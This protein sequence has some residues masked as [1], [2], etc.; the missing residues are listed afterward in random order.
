MADET[1]VYVGTVGQSLWRSRDGGLTFARASNGVHSECDEAR[2]SWADQPSS[3]TPISAGMM[4]RASC[5]TAWHYAAAP[6]LPA[7]TFLPCPIAVS[8]SAQ[9]C[10]SLRRSS[11][12]SER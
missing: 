11:M 9:D 5:R 1:T 10:I 3:N 4:R 7:T 2:N 6:N 8:T 12:Y